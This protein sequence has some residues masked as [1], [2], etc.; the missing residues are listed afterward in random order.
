MAQDHVRRVA[1]LLVGQVR[2]A[3][4]L[5]VLVSIKDE[6]G[7]AVLLRRRGH[8]Q[9]AAAAAGQPSWAGLASTSLLRAC[10][11]GAGTGR[12]GAPALAFAAPANRACTRRDPAARPAS[13]ISVPVSRRRAS[14]KR[15]MKKANLRDQPSRRIAEDSGNRTHSCRDAG[16]RA[17][18]N[19]PT[20]WTWSPS[21]CG[22]VA[23]WRRCS[24]P[25]RSRRSSRC[26]GATDEAPDRRASEERPQRPSR[27]S[28]SWTKPAKRHRDK[29]G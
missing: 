2:S 4:L 3:I 26:R 28:R 1:N 29:K 23:A 27:W 6:E 11:P 19:W 9:G 15:K 18:R 16:S 20:W 5:D 12:T 8:W 22:I 13:S 17:R 25:C 7:T 24:R 21:G 10:A 14:R